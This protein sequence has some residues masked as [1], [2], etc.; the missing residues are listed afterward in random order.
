MEVLREKIKSLDLRLAGLL[1]VAQDNDAIGRK[2]ELW[3]RSLLMTRNDVDL[4]FT[5]I[6]GLQDIFS[7]PQVTLRLWNVAPDCEHAWFA[8]PVSEDS[9]IFASG[10]R[11]P[12]CGMNN[13]FE[14]VSWLDEPTL[15][16]SIALLPL[17]IEGAT[18]A[19][20]LMVLGSPD[21]ERFASDMSTDFLTKI[22]ATASAALTC[23]LD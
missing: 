10:L 21:P 4:P 17:R 19:F 1:R 3:N 7:V 8:H 18:Q 13:D 22:G 6:S 16:Q 15:I 14:A 2:F 11:A 9:R 5:L 12:F 20:G 23:M